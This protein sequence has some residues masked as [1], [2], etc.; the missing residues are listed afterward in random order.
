MSAPAADSERRRVLVTGASRGIGAAIA[1]RLGADGAHVIVHYA[2]RADAAAAVARDV[3]E[4]GGSADVVQADLSDAASV[5]GLL[6]RLDALGPLDAYVGNAGLTKDGLVMTMRSKDWQRVL[7]VNLAAPFQ[8]LQRVLRGMLRARRGRV[9]H[10]ASIQAIR[11]GVGQPN[12]AAAKAGLL[13][14]TRAAALEVARHG[15]TVNA[16]L[17]GF[18]DTDM[19]AALQ[20]K[21]GDEILARIPMSRYGTPDDVAGVVRFLLSPDA[22]YVTGQSFVVD[23]GLSIA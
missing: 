12:Y 7:D 20:R 9:V 10:I 11:G 13:A 18:I 3:V 2:G 5:D 8:I 16:V 15:I 14:L 23:G 19:T 4:A 1:R 22:T 17:P 6:A 21:A